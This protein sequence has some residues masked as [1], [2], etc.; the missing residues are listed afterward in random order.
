IEFRVAQENRLGGL[1]KEI[2]HGRAIQL[3]ALRRDAEFQH[4][5]AV[6]AFKRRNEEDDFDAVAETGG[7]DALEIIQIQEEELLGKTEVLLQQSI[8]DERTARIGH[9]ALVFRESYGLQRVG[10]QHYGLNLGPRLDVADNNLDAVIAENLVQR[11][12]EVAFAVQVKAQR[13]QR[14]FRKDYV[15]GAAKLQSQGISRFVGADGRLQAI[16]RLPFGFG[17]FDR[18]E[19]DV[20][21]GTKFAGNAV[22]RPR[23]QERAALQR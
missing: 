23:P 1:R 13:I 12:N 14:E 11:I 22:D 4:L 10:G 2:D 7:T 16:G 20:V 17:H 5:L 21:G 19:I 9:H 6:A 3:K 15:A 18:P 8:A